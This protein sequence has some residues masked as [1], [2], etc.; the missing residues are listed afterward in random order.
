M[1]LIARQK[2]Q[3]RMHAVFRAPLD[4]SLGPIPTTVQKKNEKPLSGEGWTHPLLRKPLVRYASLQHFFCVAF[5]Q[6]SPYLFGQCLS[7]HD[8]DQTFRL[9]GLWLT[10]VQ[11]KFC[12]GS[13]FF[14]R[15]TK[16]ENLMWAAPMS[17]RRA[18]TSQCWKRSFGLHG[19]MNTGC[20]CGS[21]VLGTTEERKKAKQ[22]K[23]K[24]GGR[25]KGD[26][27]RI[28]TR[29]NFLQRKLQMKGDKYRD[30]REAPE[31]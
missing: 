8:A 10:S 1:S 15:Y 24:E 17:L 14:C 12:I 13:H 29:K 4:P 5:S 28:L 31:I 16:A 26:T 22:K 7:V 21:W 20:C 25:A 6:F 9:C 19:H 18:C 23:M 2:K 3:L 27:E 11:I 30:W